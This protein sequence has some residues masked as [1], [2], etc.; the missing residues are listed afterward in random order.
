MPCMQKRAENLQKR[1]RKDGSTMSLAATKRANERDK[2]QN[3]WEENRLLQSG[4]A[5]LREV[6]GECEGGGG[7]KRWV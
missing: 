4:V 1:V 3:A 7:G 6:G 5:R 2:D